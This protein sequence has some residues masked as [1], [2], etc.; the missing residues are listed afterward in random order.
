MKKLV[1]TIAISLLCAGALSSA[2]AAETTVSEATARAKWTYSAMRTYV[3]DHG[4]GYGNSFWLDDA[5]REGTKLN[6]YYSLAVYGK[7]GSGADCIDGSVTSTSGTCYKYN[8][9][10][11]YVSGGTFYNSFVQGGIASSDSTGGLYTVAINSWISERIKDVKSAGYRNA[12]FILD[13]YGY[14][15]NASSSYT[16]PSFDNRFIFWDYRMPAEGN[17]YI[18][19]KRTGPDASVYSYDSMKVTRSDFVHSDYTIMLRWNIHY[20]DSLYRYDVQRFS[21]FIRDS[22]SWGDSSGW[23]NVPTYGG[24]NIIAHDDGDRLWNN[25]FVS[26]GSGIEP[27]ATRSFFRL[28]MIT[29]RYDMYGVPV[30]DTTYSNVDTIDVYRTLRAS[31][32]SGQGTVSD[33]F[34]VTY[35]NNLIDMEATPAIGYSFKNWTSG[36]RAVSTKNPLRVK[37]WIDTTLKANFV[38]TPLESRLWA[39][40]YKYNGGSLT[41]NSDTSSNTFNFVVSRDSLN[42]SNYMRG[43][44]RNVK[45]VVEY[46]K[47]ATSGNFTKLFGSSTYNYS[48]TVGGYTLNNN[49]KI[50]RKGEIII[51]GSNYGSIKGNGYTQI[52]VRAVYSDSS[53]TSDSRASKIIRINWENPL[54]TISDASARAK[55]T[56]PSVTKYVSNHWWGKDSMA[57]IFDA[58]DSETEEDRYYVVGTYGKKG[59]SSNCKDAVVD[60]TSE[61]C[62]TLDGYYGYVSQSKLVS[63]RIVG[64]YTKEKGKGVRD[65]IDP[66]WL[67]NQV[68]VAKKRGYRNIRFVLDMYG[69]KK[70]T[71]TEYTYPEFGHNFI[72]WDYRLP[73]EGNIYVESID[74]GGSYTDVFDSMKITE[75]NFLNS[76]TL[77]LK[78]NI[79]YGDSLYQ[80][81]VQRFSYFIPNALSRVDSSGWVS[82]YR[83]KNITMHNSDDRLWSNVTITKETNIEPSATKSFFRLRM[84]THRYDADVGPVYDTTYSNVVTLIVNRVLEV[85]VAS[86]QGTVSPDFV[87]SVPNNAIEVK[88]TP[89]TGYSFKNWT[90]GE[91]VISEKNP[92]TVGLW[93]DTTLK[94]NFI[95]T[96]VESRLWVASYKYNGGR[97]TNNSD[98]SKTSFDFVVGRDSMNL[99]NYMKGTKRNARYFVECRVD[100]SAGEF[101]PVDTSSNLGYNSFLD[102][103][104]WENN[105]TIDSMGI[106]NVA[107]VSKAFVVGN[108]YTEIRVRAVYSDSSSASDSQS[109]KI[110]R[111]NWKYPLTFLSAMGDTLLNGAYP[112][113]TVVTIPTGRDLMGVPEDTEN[114]KYY[115][116]WMCIPFSSPTIPATAETYTV[117]PVFST[118]AAAA[119]PEYRIQFLDYDGSVLSSEWYNVNGS[120]LPPP[121]PN[122]NGDTLNF[123]FLRWDKMAPYT[124]SYSIMYLAS[125]PVDFMAVYRFRV[126][127]VDYDGSVLK[128]DFVNP[129]AAAVAPKDP[130]R[131]GCVFKGWDKTFNSIADT[132]TVQAT[133]E[134]KDK[135]SSSSAK[136]KSSSSSAKA[137]SSSSAKAK[138]SSSKAK[139]SSSKGKD[140]IAAAAQV[141]QFSL[142]AVGRNIQVA[143]ARVGSAYAVFDMQGRV[144]AKGRVAA[145]NFNL[146]MDRSATYLVR[147]GYQTQRV[148]IRD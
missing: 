123:K 48:N 71:E 50:N 73:A 46:R 70:T 80:Y 56:D 134:A 53:S 120:V 129:G 4:W 139:S 117:Q 106:L 147:I 24:S 140:A 41:S 90:S 81:D 145:A 35:G 11:G 15:T 72:F 44:K 146:T 19:E 77:K 116:Y 7:K 36:E 113:D 3:A 100:T 101:I 86:D 16:Y 108:R 9:D 141:P 47:D 136:A 78:W 133:Y 137:K 57:W 138:S 67:K 115:Y 98:T 20:G 94:A 54:A 25:F 69:Y 103:K 135:S 28:R 60:T 125:D 59:H 74:Y 31:V 23:V 42:L 104:T 102:G 107:G 148:V 51:A 58:Y 99:S 38:V 64:A 5:Y 96:P 39:T 114:T 119:E 92:L 22:I 29:H 17:F 33:D 45:Y 14:R 63:T 68:S 127:F 111:I 105:I 97:L 128:S 110:I 142:M 34:I 122:H 62:Y 75:T 6:R 83:G 49:I 109:S 131:E 30:Y 65:V 82:V 27:S 95:I 32:G 79:H 130:T 91:K 10:Y 13:N 52:R 8:G 43:T 55:W 2:L 1:R 66:S 84:I 85:D 144:I 112:K 12:R 21:Y 76:Y 61:T 143:G 132:L 121:S 126:K 37:L 93:I 18:K 124:G 118:F 40:S 26:K 87:V 88:A 89:A